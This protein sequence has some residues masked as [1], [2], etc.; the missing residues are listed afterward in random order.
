MPQ[1]KAVAVADGTTLPLARSAVHQPFVLAMNEGVQE[2]IYEASDLG[3]YA[4]HGGKS[5]WFGFRIV[6]RQLEP[7]APFVVVMQRRSAALPGSNDWLRVHV[8]DV[9]A[10]Q[11]LVSMTDA[12]GGI[13]A[14]SR[15]MGENDF[16]EIQ[17]AKKAHVLVLERLVNRLVGND[18]VSFQIVDKELFQPD[19]I[20][21]FIRRVAESDAVFVREGMEHNAELARQFLRARHVNYKG[22]KRTPEQ[23]VEAASKSLTT[24]EPYHVKLPDGTTVT[25]KEWFTGQLQQVRKELR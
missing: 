1:A 24:G 12:K 11:V 10:G 14:R 23:F 20:A 7:E 4:N 15:S 2:S 21:Q 16:I 9:T 13:I 5:W 3:V 6:P 17:L 25:A 22:P 18:H 8:G 19:V